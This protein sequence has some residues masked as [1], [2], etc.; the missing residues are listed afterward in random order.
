[1][2]STAKQ[3]PRRRVS[4]QGEPGAF[5]EEAIFKLLGESV[6]PHPC[7]TFEAA[8]DSLE[9]GVV[10]QALVPLENS[11]AGS[12]HRTYDLL[13][14]KNFHIVAE[15]I[16]PVVHNLIA[17]PGVTLDQIKTVQSHPVALSQCLNFFREYPF[18]QCKTAE[19]TAGS[20]REVLQ[21]NDPSVAAI[22]GT[23]AAK[24]YGGFI[25]LEHLEDD[26]ENYTRFVL[27]SHSPDESTNANKLSLVVKLKHHP[28]ALHGAL[29]I[30]AQRNINLC[31]IE[32]RPLRG[33][34]WQYSFY[35]DVEG[36]RAEGR[37]DDALRG[38][39]ELAEELR[40][41]GWYRSAN[42]ASTD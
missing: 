29:G 1:M 26:P 20:V 30:F 14:E 19:D 42:S 24:L 13:L 40:V 3:K 12:I 18:I 25:L 37:M 8:F 2:R 21:K 11:L 32:S 5:S 9:E 28:G 6:E 7:N 36:R 16:I 4:F 22:A 33:S 31:K 34:P 10:Q 17:C 15:V 35:L 38:L 27:L 23:R 41:L 39:A